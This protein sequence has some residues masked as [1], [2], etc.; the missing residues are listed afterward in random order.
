MNQTLEGHQGWDAGDC[1]ARSACFV[2]HLLGTKATLPPVPLPEH[3]TNFIGRFFLSGTI[4]VIT[5]NENFRK[6]TTSDQPDS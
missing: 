4:M 3:L 5:W 6:L 1:K 2:E